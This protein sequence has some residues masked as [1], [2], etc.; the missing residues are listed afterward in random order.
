MSAC[1]ARRVASI[2]FLLP[3]LLLASCGSEEWPPVEDPPPG[4][5]DLSGRELTAFIIARGD[6]L[7]L[8]GEWDPPPGDRIELSTAGFA[9]ILCSAV[10][11]TGLDPADAA[12]NV[13]YFSAPYGDRVHVTDTIIDYE[14]QEVR[15]GLP[16]RKSVV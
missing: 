8:P 5:T 12:E 7:E 15:L 2:A 1:P 4:P 14:N 11:I 16:D 9:K 6:S 10:F 3:M 13:G